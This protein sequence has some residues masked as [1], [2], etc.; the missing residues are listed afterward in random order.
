MFW[1][2][3]KKVVEERVERSDKKVQVAPTVSVKLKR[4][5][6][7][8]AHITGQPIKDV[9]EILC[10]EGI[11]INSVIE[12]LSRYQQRGEL[13]VEQSIY[14]GNS[15]NPKLSDVKVEG[16]TGRLSVRFKRYDFE[17][18]EL[19]A[20]LLSVNPSRTVAA[21]ID[22]SIRHPY[23]VETMMTRYNKRGAC[24]EVSKD[25]RAFMRHVRRD[26]PYN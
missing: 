6:E 19:L 20:Y 24:E 12:R 17:N 2:R 23:I 21:L 7:R 26:N 4:E 10:N 8:L 1:K 22:E 5:V 3:R 11:R 16:P 15:D 18:I 13:R 14:F 25:L 9:C